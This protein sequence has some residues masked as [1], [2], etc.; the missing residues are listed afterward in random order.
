MCGD[1]V[2][3]GQAL[4]WVIGIFAVIIRGEMASGRQ[5]F[6]GCGKGVA[7]STRG[8]GHIS[9][10]SLGDPL[11]ASVSSAIE[12]LG[13]EPPSQRQTESEGIASVLAVP[14]TQ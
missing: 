3:P 8:N 12:S 7:L 4:I 6:S 5:G 14:H 1:W 13:P 9:Q 10:R 11:W 2:H